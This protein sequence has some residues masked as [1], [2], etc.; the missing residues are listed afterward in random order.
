[1]SRPNLIGRFTPIDA[2]NEETY[3]REQ[4]DRLREDIER[5]RRQVAPQ[6]GLRVG[7]QPILVQGVELYPRE[8]AKLHNTHLYELLDGKDSSLI[9]RRGQ[10]FYMAV[11]FKK[12]FNPVLDS[13]RLHFEFGPP[14]YL[15]QK[16]NLVSL[17]ITN[18]SAFTREKAMWDIRTHQHEG[19]LITL[20]IQVAGTAPVGVWKMKIYS[21]VPGNMSIEPAVFEIPQNVYIL[22]NPWSKEDTVF[23]DREDARREY[24]L[25]DV[26]KIFVGT[27]KEPRGRRWIYGQFADSV[28]PAAML[29]LNHSKLDYTGRASPILVSRAISKLVNSENDDKGI[30]VGNWSGMYDDGMAPWMWTGSAAIMDEYFKNGGEQ[31]V[32]YGQCWVFAGV[33]TTV[34]RTLGLPCRTVTNF[35]SAHDTDRS[36]TVDKYFDEKGEKIEGVSNDSIWN[37]HVW[38]DVW[39]ARPD[40]PPG[41]GGWQSIDSTPQETSGNV[42]QMGPASVEAVK[43]GQVGFDFD[44]PFVFAEVNADII[45]W[46]RDETVEGGW[47]KAASDK[48][49]IG[50]FMLTKKI[51]VDD[52]VGDTD[53]ENI[54]AE[55]KDQEGTVE[56][57]MAVLN[58]ARYGVAPSIRYAVY[59]MPPPEAEDVDFDLV[60]IDQVMIGQ[61]FSVTVKVRNKNKSEMRTVGAVLSAST[62]YYTGVL[63][64]KVTRQRGNFTLKPNQSEVLSITVTPDDYLDK[65]VD[66]SMM[67]IYA[68][69]T[70]QETQQ[71]WAEEDDFTVQKPKLRLE[72]PDTLRVSYEFQLVIRLTNPLNRHLTDCLFTIEGPGLSGP[73][74][75][76]FRDISPLESVVH[77]E[78]LVP[79]RPGKRVIVVNFSSRQLIEVLGSKHV[80]VVP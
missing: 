70:V 4:Y 27:Q 18:Q 67:K 57:R 15:M 37:F 5:T 64:R 53:A 65:L 34:C 61:P 52:D 59:D 6:P 33:A 31:S 1:M 35:V 16:G 40:L 30:V 44:C 69:A 26:G 80:N 17:P 73:Y 28:L 38:N 14:P 68:I 36:L 22:F 51:G 43:R 63:A 60:E 75:V 47:R 3:R 66:Y 62:V 54:V 9:I 79:Q 50:Q 48:Y 19:A 12:T 20:D 39:M 25:N 2:P 58:A 21:Y 49:K 74:R 29:M 77:V 78:R 55:Y 10:T 32:K 42:F 23:L 72:C 13:V 71:T 11:R 24:V 56:E 41:Y 8:N 46:T 76:K 45:K 7:P